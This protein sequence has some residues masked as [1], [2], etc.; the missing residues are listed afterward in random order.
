VPGSAHRYLGRQPFFAGET[1][2]LADLAAYAHLEF[3]E[4]SPEGQDL[5][6]GSSLKP[7][8]ARMAAQPSARNTTWAVLRAAAELQP[9]QLRA[10]CR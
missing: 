3:T 7:W 9:A 8:L 6:A 4:A 5:L 10:L 1:I 2:S